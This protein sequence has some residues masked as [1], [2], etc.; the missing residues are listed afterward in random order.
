MS[1]VP[2]AA[3]LPL[4]RLLRR[5]SAPD[6]S[7]PVYACGLILTVNATVTSFSGISSVFFSLGS[8]LTSIGLSQL[9]YSEEVGCHCCESVLEQCG[10]TSG[11]LAEEGQ[12][13]NWVFRGE[14]A[15]LMRRGVSH[16]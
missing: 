6:K 4:T 2:S 7:L 1:T 13:I 5:T 8:G 12:G 3:V 14:M 9:T 11:L 15:N 16:A 10:S